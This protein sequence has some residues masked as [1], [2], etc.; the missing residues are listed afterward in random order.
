LATVGVAFALALFI[1]F[2]P[3]AGRPAEAVGDLDI[4]SVAYAGGNA[5]RASGTWQ[6]RGNQCWGPGNE[7]HYLIEIYDDPDGLLPVNGDLLAVVDPAPCNGDYSAPVDS[8]DRGTGGA[9]PAPG[10][11]GNVFSLGPG[12]HRICAVLRHVSAS[13]N[14]IAAQTCFES[15][16]GVFVVS[17]DFQPNGGG[18]VSVHLSCTSGSVSP[19]SIN[20]SESSAATFGVTN[21][22]GSPT[23]TADESNVPA[24]YT[25]N[26]GCSAPL[27]TGQCTIVNTALPS[28][29]ADSEPAPN[30]AA[31]TSTP[32][33]SS[34]TPAAPTATPVPATTPQA[35]APQS[36][37]PA[38]PIDPPAGSPPQIRPPSTGNG[39]L[40]PR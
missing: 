33:G 23:C 15:S 27:S 31:P 7:F 6:P 13:G 8:A 16:V 34:P 30:L 19:G 40:V 12:L 14:D 37:P 3:P 35:G 29:P 39:G 10:Q 24:G 21:A 2:S 36:P 17:K 11:G 5:F 1:A 32:P 38:A 26:A 22:S 28:G 18:S 25:S 20:A 4:V 9:W